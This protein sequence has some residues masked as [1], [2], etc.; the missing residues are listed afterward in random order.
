MKSTCKFRQI[1]CHVVCAVCPL[2]CTL[3]GLTFQMFACRPVEYFRMVVM[4]PATLNKL[5]LRGLKPTG[6]D[7]APLARLTSQVK[8]HAIESCLTSPLAQLP[9]LRCFVGCFLSDFQALKAKLANVSATPEDLTCLLRRP[10]M[11]VDSTVQCCQQMTLTSGSQSRY[12]T[13]AHPGLVVGPVKEINCHWP[14]K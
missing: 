7:L 13:P 1:W 2:S 12:L 10:D 5:I 11:S 9:A 3:Q 8:A 6:K 4:V 14:W